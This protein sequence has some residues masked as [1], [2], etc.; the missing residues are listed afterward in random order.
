[1]RVIERIYNTVLLILFYF[2]LTSSYANQSTH[3]IE[4]LVNDNI[5]TNYDIAQHFAL[6]SIIDNISVTSENGDALYKKT[7]NELIDMKLQQAKIKDYDIKYEENKNDYYENY[8]FQSKK[9]DRKKV[10]QIIKRNNID[11]SALKEKIKTLITW[12]QLTTGLF[13]HTISISESEINALLKKDDSLSPELAKRILL[14]RQVQLKSEK[15]LR[16]LRAEA[17]IEKR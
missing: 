15:Y 9:L 2:I 14:N 4:I 6:N 5:I 13:L 7:V 3:K 16:D 8:F 11:I 12:E 1:M 10:Y 17:N